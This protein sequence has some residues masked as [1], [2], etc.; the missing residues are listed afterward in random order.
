M[1]V[2]GAQGGSCFNATGG[3]GGY[4][5]GN[6]SVT[7]NTNLY[8]CIGQCTGTI[9]A[10]NTGISSYNGGGI[11]SS[12][13]GGATHIAKTNRGELK[14]YSSYKSEILI[15]AGGGGAGADGGFGTGIGGAGGGLTGG[16]GVESAGIGRI[17]TG[18]SQTAAGVNG[19]HY[20]H[21]KFVTITEPGFGQGGGLYD[22][23][24]YGGGG[25]SGWYGGGGYPYAGSGA[26]GS[27]YIGGVIN[28]ITTAGVQTGNGKAV[29][30]WMPVL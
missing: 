15:V 11:G 21:N 14:N 17:A 3:K 20:W 26:G 12:A 27:G 10:D 28:G 22:D 9:S 2:W 16:D 30:T 19:I 24:N 7:L 6:L 1:E 5:Y 4:S 23:S 18:G 8:V 25:G 29:I 13:G